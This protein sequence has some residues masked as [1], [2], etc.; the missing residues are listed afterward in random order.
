MSHDC[1]YYILKCVLASADDIIKAPFDEHSTTLCTVYIPVEGG[2]F[3]VV[4]TDR[5]FWFGL[6]HFPQRPNYVT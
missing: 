6:S 5:G 3:Y 2:A 4:W 1:S